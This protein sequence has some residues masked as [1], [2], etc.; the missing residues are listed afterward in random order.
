MSEEDH[1][2]TETERWAKLLGAIGKNCKIY[3]GA[4][5]YNPE[6][7]E[8]E[9]FVDIYC[10]VQLV[11]PITIGCH[12]HIGSKCALHGHKGIWIG[13]YVAVG[14][15]TSIWTSSNQYAPRDKLNIEYRLL[16][17]SVGIDDDV[18]VGA[19]CTILPGCHLLTG[20]VLGAKSLLLLGTIVPSY[21]IWGGHPARKIGERE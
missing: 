8:L 6:L 15:G 5:I 17:A 11:G 19:D 10:D 1:W 9:D 18:F 2:K 14:G 13:R 12:S 16:E 3:E 7:I 21:E 4:R 20:S